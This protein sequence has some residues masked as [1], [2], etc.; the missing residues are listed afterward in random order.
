MNREQR[1]SAGKGQSDER[2][3]VSGIVVHFENGQYQQ[4]DTSKIQIVDKHTG[5]P[6]FEEVLEPVPKQL[7]G[8]KN[9]VKPNQEFVN[10]PDRDQASYTVT[11]DTPEGKMTYVKNGNWSGVRPANR[12]E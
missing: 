10:E 4:L 9:A 3:N 11:F 2:L 1:R 7:E 5:R 12:G 8:N 6:L